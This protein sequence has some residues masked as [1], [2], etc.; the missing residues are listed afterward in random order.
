MSSDVGR[1]DP[2]PC[3][4]GKKYKNCCG[5]QGAKSDSKRWTGLRS[6]VLAIVIVGGGIAAYMILSE[7]TAA[8]PEATTTDAI[9]KN[10][11]PI[12]SR[13]PGPAPEGKVWS[14]E[15]GHWHDSSG[16]ASDFATK[17]TPQPPGPAPDGKVWS[18]EH[19]HWHNASGAATPFE[20]S[21][22]PISITPSTTTQSLS[23]TN[24][25]SITPG[26]TPKPGAEPTPQPPGPPPEGKVWFA[27]HGHWHDAPG[28]PGELTP[29]P[30]GPAP[31]G[32][33]WVPEHGHWHNAP[34]AAT[35]FEPGANKISITPSKPPKT[36][37]EDPE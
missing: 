7:P 37:S 9:P 14:D 30:P 35:P 24:P 17:F 6:G 11:Q 18:S 23:G 22:N 32:K 21:T 31:E 25:I 4:S 36:G 13:P 34:A 26:I 28:T 33:V 2:C 8:P 19:G 15:H 5:K 27:E 10:V 16:S 3:G 20:S 1:R 12:Q 29:Q